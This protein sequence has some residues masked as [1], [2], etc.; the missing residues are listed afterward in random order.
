MRNTISLIVLALTVGIGMTA[1]RQ[2]S[3]Q[4]ATFEVASIKASKSTAAGSTSFPPGGR[5]LAKNATLKR[6]MRTAYG[7]LDSQIEG[8][9]S[10]VTFD[11]FD[12][13]ARSEGTASSDQVRIMLQGLLEDRFKL[14]V[15]RTTKQDSVYTCNGERWAEDQG[16]RGCG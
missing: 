2:T 12:V 14:K 16:G 13:E 3:L 6:L 8:G 10:W 11:K 5:F 15:H 7:V 1:T 4:R 9:P